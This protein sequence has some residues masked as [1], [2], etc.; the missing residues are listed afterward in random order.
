ME[1][2][3]TRSKGGA[4]SL[5]SGAHPWR[6]QRHDAQ[7]R[8]GRCLA[9]HTLPCCWRW[10]AAERGGL[11]F[12]FACLGRGGLPLP[13]L[14]GEP[15][16]THLSK[17]FR[18]VPSLVSPGVTQ[19]QSRRPLNKASQGLPTPT[20]GCLAERYMAPSC[21]RTPGL[22]S[23]ASPSLS[24]QEPHPQGVGGTGGPGAEGWARLGARWVGGCLPLPSAAP[25]LL[26][27]PPPL[28]HSVS[29][30]GASFLSADRP[31]APGHACA[32]QSLAD[33]RARRARDVW[34]LVPEGL[35][36]THSQ[37]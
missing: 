26:A 31:A 7:G 17:H 33:T 30:R 1:Q 25:R 8:R 16:A 29:P 22:L 3:D 18:P 9:Q 10:V 12:L 5:D 36:T 19:L 4:W 28:V 27:L 14:P 23:G 24:V 37:P 13:E 2:R 6:G 35:P 11:G 34:R 32:L 15:R 20:G 21:L